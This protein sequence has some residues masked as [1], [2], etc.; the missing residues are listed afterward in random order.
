MKKI[1]KHLFRH[2]EYLLLVLL[3]LIILTS[4]PLLE[5]T[6][7][8]SLVYHWL[9]TLLL[10]DW[11]ASAGKKNNFVKTW[12]FLWWIALILN[13]IEYLSS[14]ETI[15]LLFMISTFLFF[16][17]ITINVILSLL[18][19]KKTSLHTIIGS[20]AG[21]LMIWMAWSYLFAIIETLQPN[22]FS[23]S[24]E[25]IWNIPSMLYY[26]FVT[27]LTLW[28]WDMVPSWG[29]AQMRSVLVAVAGQL[30]LVILM[31]VLIWKYVRDK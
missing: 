25:Y 5:G 31:W 11:V 9:I 27:M 21:Y 13:R 1:M 23:P 30:Y 14:T 7:R 29:H 26:T 8:W 20:I 10:I 28:Y 24:V 22:S 4:Y 3:T 12:L 6:E 17:L 16:V 19:H 2:H 18:E 15:K